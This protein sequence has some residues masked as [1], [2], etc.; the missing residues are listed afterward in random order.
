[1]ARPSIE[2]TMIR[3]SA[4]RSVIKEGDRLDCC[5]CASHYHSLCVSIPPGELKKLSSEA[6]TNWLC[7]E[8]RNKKPRGDNSNM[9]VRQP[10]SINPEPNPNSNVTQRRK[11]QESDTSSYLNITQ[12]DMRKIIQEEISIVVKEYVRDLKIDLNRQ[13]KDFKDEISGLTQSIQF[14]NDTFEKFNIDLQECKTNIENFAKEKETFQRDLNIITRRLNQ[15]E[16]ISRSSNLEIQCVPERKTENVLSMVTQLSKAV[17]CPINESDIHYCSRIAKK[18]PESSRPRS[19]LVKL[20]SPRSRDSL[21][22]AVIKYNKGHP[23]NKL[24]TE[25]VGFGANKKN[26]IYVVENLSHENK[27]LHS[28]ARSR[29][30]ELQYKHVWIRSGRIYMR[31]TD[32]SEYILVRSASTLD[33]LI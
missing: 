10:T 25:H 5:D 26:S 14:I 32:T 19:I 6:K 3:C 23:Q 2:P 13:L 7:P 21:L 31:K 12:A 20:N 11:K 4:C 33:K 18:N 24:N 9:P 22:A 17:S 30:K 15:V 16:Q 29:A 28:M 8:C 27:L 1:V